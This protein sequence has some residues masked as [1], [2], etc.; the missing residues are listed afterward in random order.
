MHVK[1]FLRIESAVI[2]VFA[3]LIYFFAALGPWWL[4]VALIFAPDIFMLGYIINPKFG[5]FTYNLFH[6]YFW[7]LALIIVGLFTDNLWLIWSGF[8]WMAHIGI[9]RA[10]GYGLKYEDG[11]K[12]THM[13]KL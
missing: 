9:D 3:T 5:S 12:I 11:F 6:I 4:Y 8:V 10:I 2:F 13:Q 7:S 1:L